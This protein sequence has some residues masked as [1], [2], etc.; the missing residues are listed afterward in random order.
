M[1]KCIA[2]SHLEVQDNTNFHTLGYFYGGNLVQMGVCNQA[3][4][5]NAHLLGGGEEGFK[6]EGKVKLNKIHICRQAL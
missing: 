2:S 1:V 4:D 6:L 5:Y 3:K